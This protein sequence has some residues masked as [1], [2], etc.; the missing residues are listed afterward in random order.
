M[1]CFYEEKWPLLFVLKVTGL[2]SYCIS[3]SGKRHMRY[4]E[5]YVQN[6]LIWINKL[7]QVI[8][9]LFQVSISQSGFASG[10]CWVIKSYQCFEGLR[11]FHLQVY[12][13]QTLST[14]LGLLNTEGKETSKISITT[15]I[16]KSS[17]RSIPQDMNRH[18]YSIHKTAFILDLGISTY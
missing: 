12:A 10:H 11:C 7:S 9:I 1:K 6:I 5:A 4:V 3:S 18:C 15:C 14:Q 2:F 16:Y 17:R 13:V 8:V